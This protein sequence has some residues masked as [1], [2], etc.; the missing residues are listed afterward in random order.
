MR[1]S[2]VN[3]FLFT[4]R[5]VN[6][7]DAEFIEE[8][9]KPELSAMICAQQPMYAEQMQA[10]NAY[11]DRV[12]EIVRLACHRQQGAHLTMVYTRNQSCDLE[13]LDHILLKA[14]FKCE[15]DGG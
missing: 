2:N 10:R 15:F 7:W 5:G 8:F 12:L 6:V 3:E 9:V 13:K 14:L 1:V 11:R 4:Y